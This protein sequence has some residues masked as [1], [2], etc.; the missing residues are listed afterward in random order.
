MDCKLT[1]IYRKDNIIVDQLA[2]MSAKE[3]NLHIFRS[4]ELPPMIKGC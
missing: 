3:S 2:H 1:H 4:N